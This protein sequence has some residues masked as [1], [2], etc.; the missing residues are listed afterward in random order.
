MI[1]SDAFRQANKGLNQEELIDKFV[2]EASLR[3]RHQ[4]IGRGEFECKLALQKCKAAAE[5]NKDTY[6][7]QI[8]KR[9]LKNIFSF[10]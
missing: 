7:N 9:I 8:Y 5:T 6:L 1:I 3:H 10:K 2:S 4:P